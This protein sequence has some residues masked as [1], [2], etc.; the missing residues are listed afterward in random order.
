MKTTLIILIHHVHFILKLSSSN[1]LKVKNLDNKKS[2]ILLLFR[3]FKLSLTLT[4]FDIYGGLGVLKNTLKSILS[5]KKYNKNGQKTLSLSNFQKQKK[6]DTVFLLG[7]G[8][9]INKLNKADWDQIKLKDSWGFNYWFCHD[10]VPDCFFAQSH[11]KSPE[12]PEFDLNMDI[13]MTQMLTDK[14]SE[15]KKV[16]F[17]LR[18]D[19]VNKYTFHES[20]FG[21]T[22]LSNDLNCFFMSELVV[23]STINI[24]PEYILKKLCD[25]GFFSM[26]DD[27]TPVPKL[28]NTITELISLALISG[29]KKIILCGVD[30]ND[31]SHFYD[32]DYYLSKYD[33][34][35]TL[36][37][38]C[39]KQIV[40]P[41]MDTNIKKYTNKDIIK[42]LQKLANQE[43]DCQIY[44][45]NDTSQLYP[46]IPKYF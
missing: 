30:M 40:H 14:V 36:K 2:Q 46:D 42:D 24:K 19:N 4:F 31:E 13:L 35:R 44:V 28:G 29:Y 25:F 15:Y 38:I 6:S 26:Y 7:S 21:K 3:L 18:G 16:R 41:H 17:Y 43:F 32:T 1:F 37:D 33:Y 12:G 23:S 39:D 9:S 34:L 22:I 5:V 11:L 27:N 10:H 20:K 8:P 45:S